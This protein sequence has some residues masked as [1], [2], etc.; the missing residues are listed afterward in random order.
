MAYVVDA[1][2]LVLYIFLLLLVAR[3]VISWV[4]VFARSWKPRGLSLL[5]VEAVLTVT[6]P[7]LKLLRKV[8]PD[9]ALGNMRF[10]LGFLVLFLLVSFMISALGPA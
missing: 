2:R 1:V 7:P 9:L 5:V 8:L 4:M 3:L 6:D 10:D